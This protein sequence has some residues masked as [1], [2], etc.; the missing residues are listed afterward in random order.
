M[1]MIF[2]KKITE[3]KFIVD[4]KVNLFFSCKFFIKIQNKNRQPIIISHVDQRV[5]HL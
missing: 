4:E 5:L 2:Q 3:I 1:D